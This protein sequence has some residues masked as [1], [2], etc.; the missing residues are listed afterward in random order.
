MSQS[1]VSMEL[2]QLPV[3]VLLLK[4]VKMEGE[5]GTGPSKK[6]KTKLFRFHRECE[7]LFFH[8][9][10][11]CVCLICQRIVTILKKGKCRAAL[12]GR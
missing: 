4:G 10:F 12:L 1:S 5:G 8:S 3:N 2:T 11:K 7:D 6:N 9:R